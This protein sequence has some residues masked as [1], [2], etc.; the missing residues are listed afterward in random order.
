VPGGIPDIDQKADFIFQIE[1]GYIIRSENDI[2]ITL[3]Q[4]NASA[5]I[6]DCTFHNN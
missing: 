3:P 4:N 5:I 2:F 6:I 1:I